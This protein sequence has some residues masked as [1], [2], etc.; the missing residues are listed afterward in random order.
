MA[1]RPR[2]LVAVLAVAALGLTGSVLPPANAAV[3]APP[4]TPRATCG[5]G[6]LP[7]TGMQGRVSAADVAAGK[8][9]NGF[10]CNMVQIGYV[11][12]SGGYKV[13]R[14]VDKAG[15]ECAYFDTTLLFPT[16]AAN[17]AQKGTGVAVV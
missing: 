14:F 9:K 6:S 2:V 8:V 5:P 1:A 13:E 7:E 11:G 4:P 15:H 17:I 16:N 10:R 3:V 12:S